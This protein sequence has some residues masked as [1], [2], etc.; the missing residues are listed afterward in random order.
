MKIK[1]TQ[2]TGDYQAGLI[3]EVHDKEAQK[4]IDK[5]IAFEVV[6]DKTPAIIE[7]AKKVKHGNG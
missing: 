4:L 1:I 7:G 3:Y 2:K 6:E 5:D